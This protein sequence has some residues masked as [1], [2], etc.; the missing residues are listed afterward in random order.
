MSKRKK[1]KVMMILLVLMIYST[2][3]GNYNVVGDPKPPSVSFDWSEE[4]YSV[5]FEAEWDGTPKAINFSGYYADTYTYH[6]AYFNSTEDTLTRK[7][8]TVF[9]EAN[10]SNN[11]NSTIVGDISMNVTLDI[12]RVDISYGK[13][14]KFIWAAVK[15]GT[16]EVERNM[17]SEGYN[18][19]YFEEY[20]AIIETKYRKYNATQPP[21]ELMSQWNETDEVW[22]ELNATRDLPPS[23]YNTTIIERTKFSTPLIFIM[24]LYTTENGDK[25]AWATIF[26]DFIFYKHKDN[27]AIYSAGETTEVLSNAPNLWTSSEFCGWMKPIALKKYY[28]HINRE[29]GIEFDYWEYYPFDKTVD[30]VASTIQFTP[31]TTTTGL[32][33][34]W[35]IQYPNFPIDTAIMDKDIPAKDR[36]YIPPNATYD[37]TSPG[38]FSYGFD[39]EVAAEQA[40][41][42]FTLGIPRLTNQSFY[43]A[44]QGYGLALPHYNYFLASFDIKEKNQ[45]ELTVP[46]DIFTFESNDTIVAE[47]NMNNPEKRNYTLH[48]YPTASEDS[49]IPAEGGS[50]NTLLLSAIELGGNVINYFTNFIYGIRDEVA[51]DAEFIVTDD[52]YML[53]TQNYPVWSGNEITHDPSSTVFFREQAEVDTPSERIPGYHPVGLMT[54]LFVSAIIII[55]KNRKKL[56]NTKGVLP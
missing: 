44:V 9:Y 24:Q 28:Y 50:V 40:S 46:A 21:F 26:H 11:A 56:K 47:I 22:D 43:D 55:I 12:Y 3:F 4:T 36:F 32:D 6:D 19:E 45:R 51:K 8:S 35:G 17:M 38:T 10:Y 7:T 20:H 5:S 25:I 27:D 33:V 16:L 14:V 53:E 2:A 54:I 49:I 23:L 31:P 52:L 37:G 29:W 42:D 39:Y 13:D 34:S 18:Y 30:E 1:S 48:D 41:L 15:N